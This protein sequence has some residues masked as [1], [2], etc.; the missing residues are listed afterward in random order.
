MAVIRRR[1]PPRP[2]GRWV[3][4]DLTEP[5]DIGRGDSTPSPLD[6]VFPPHLCDFTYADRYTGTRLAA[7]RT[8]AATR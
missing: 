8:L 4:L 1:R 5:C 3:E 7:D 2:T 6:R